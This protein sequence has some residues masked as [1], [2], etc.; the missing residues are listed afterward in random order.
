MQTKTIND[1][2]NAVIDYYKEFRA[3]DTVRSCIKACGI[4]QSYYNEHSKTDYHP[5]INEE[6][7]NRIREN[8]VVLG[9]GDC[10]AI[11]RILGMLDDYYNSRP[12]REKY[13]FVGRYKHLLQP[14]YQQLAEDFRESLTVAEN[15][16][17]VVYSVARDF[18]YYLQESEILDMSK[19]QHDT[20]YEFLLWEYPNRKGSMNYVAYVLRMICDYLNKNGFQQVTN[21]FLPFSLPSSRKKVYPAF[22]QEDMKKILSQPDTSKPAGK[23]DYAV[24][25]LAS[26]T[27]MRAV[28]I[29][30]LK[31]PDI[32]WKEMTVDFIQRKTGNTVSLPLDNRA[33]SAVSDYILNGRPK[34]DNSY[35]FLTE[36]T[37]FR[38]LSDK[39][40]VA[41][42]LIK[43]VKQ[44]GIDKTS[45]DGKSFHAFRRNMGIWLLEA[46]VDPEL[47][48]QILG[49]QSRDVLKNYLPI[50]TSKLDICALSFEGIQ[51]RT[52]VYQ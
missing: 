49:H 41:N 1:G 33:A 47:I 16:V 5:N 8:R 34:A 25:V 52:E 3:S 42:I 40:S 12:Y 22:C 38:K 10:R 7:R 35:V 48:S 6:I 19:I 36:T 9:H 30:N 27:A 4:I 21:D 11:F 51:V 14:A 29:A 39:S 15:T 24:L 28:D 23:R 13:P 2:I 32:R 44:A 50:A 46:A 37:P 20:L 43:Y 26:V 45:R 31:L 18:F 17:P